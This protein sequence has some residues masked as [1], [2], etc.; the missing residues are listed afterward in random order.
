[1]KVAVLISG[2]PRFTK[3]FDFFLDN[4]S[5]YDQMDFFFYLWN[6]WPP[7]DQ[8]IPKTWS[9]DEAIASEKI[10]KNLPKNCNLKKLKITSPPNYIPNPN[11]RLTQWSF[12]V[13]MWYQWYSLKM[14]NGLRVEHEKD[15]GNYD[16]VIRARPDVGIREP[17]SLNWVYQYVQKFPNHIITPGNRRVGMY[18]PV[19]D[20][21]GIGTGEAISVWC[22]LVDNV[23][24]YHNTTDLPYTCETFLGYHL[25]VNGIELPASDIYG[26]FREYCES[27]G[28]LNDH[29]RWA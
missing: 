27:Q 28:P 3:E 15:Y 26:I 21:F 17:L 1:M 16:L 10:S 24:K 4:A 5:D 29:G 8:R 2:Q 18:I 20:W 19:N 11:L 7:T 13:D 6:T 25:K 12:P 22:S 9:N 14:V 23:E